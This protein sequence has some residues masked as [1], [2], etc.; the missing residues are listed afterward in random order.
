MEI[1]AQQNDKIKIIKKT[2]PPL[3]KPFIF[4]GFD[5]LYDLFNDKQFQLNCYVKFE[6]GKFMLIEPIIPQQFGQLLFTEKD[7]Q[8]I[9]VEVTQ[10]N[11]CIWFTCSSVIRSRIL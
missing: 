4:K 7:N 2:I 9:D 8:I 5:F 3:N 1:P 10:F 11:K 6:D